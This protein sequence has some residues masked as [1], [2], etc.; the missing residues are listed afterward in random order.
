MTIKTL[1]QIL[2]TPMNGEQGAMFSFVTY[3]PDTTKISLTH[4]HTYRYYL[5][6]PCT[7]SMIFTTQPQA[8][9]CSS[10]RHSFLSLFYTRKKKY[11]FLTYPLF[12]FL[13]IPH[14]C[15][16]VP[17]L[18]SGCHILGKFIDTISCFKFSWIVFHF[19]PS[20]SPSSFGR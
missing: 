19:R 1:L 14:A 6:N 18:L 12:L 7:S 2:V 4:T 5:Y 16:I 20:S 8:W 3:Q 11:H 17:K 15:F 10:P 9:R 13:V